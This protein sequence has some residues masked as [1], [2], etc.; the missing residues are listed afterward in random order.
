[1]SGGVAPHPKPKGLRK[2]E[3]KEIKM[4]LTEAKV[5]E[6]KAEV[7]DKT[8]T[9]FR[10]AILSGIKGT[11]RKVSEDT[12]DGL[13]NLAMDNVIDEVLLQHKW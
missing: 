9:A 8:A 7:S 1:M 11:D 13:F 6:I 5:E 10:E 4:E 2:Q 3:R 12:I